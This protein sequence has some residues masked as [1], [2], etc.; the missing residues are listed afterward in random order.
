MVV[1]AAFACGGCNVFFPV[2]GYQ[3]LEAG[4]LQQ[5]TETGSDTRSLTVMLQEPTSGDALIV[6][7]ASVNGPPISVTGG[8]VTWT[9]QSA[10]TEHV[11]LAVWTGF[12]PAAG[13]VE[14]VTVTWKAAPDAA[15]LNALV[16]LSEWIGPR[17]IGTF[18]SSAGTGGPITTAN[19]VVSDHATLVLAAAGTHGDPLGMPTGDFVALDPRIQ[20]NNQL[21][22]AYVLSPEPRT[23]ATSWSYAGAE[24]WDAVVMSFLE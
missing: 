23:Y 7:A 2:G 19:L 21:A 16:H 1:V 10:T 11:A 22:A 12:A 13:S 4:L 8:G 6:V 3:G 17:A 24:S 14:P 15:Q 5:A 18:A 20:N 9:Q